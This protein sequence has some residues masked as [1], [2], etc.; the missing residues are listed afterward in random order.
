MYHYVP[1][2]LGM[3]TR[4]WI[5]ASVDIF[6][7]H[8]TGDFNH[9]S[10]F[11]LNSYQLVSGNCTEVLFL[12]IEL[13]QNWPV[14]ANVWTIAAILDYNRPHHFLW[15]VFSDVSREFYGTLRVRRSECCDIVTNDWFV[16]VMYECKRLSTATHANWNDVIAIVFQLIVMLI[17]SKIH[18]F[19]ANGFCQ[20][21]SKIFFTIT[22]SQ[23]I[24]FFYTL[25][26]WH[27]IIMNCFGECLYVF[28][29]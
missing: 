10:L 29:R 27:L 25:I 28:R 7:K 14:H 4:N 9:V 18:L 8:M 21:L 6:V 12:W 16:N 15:A 13:M 17:P 22:L 3:V 20:C 26:Y 11:I 1:L 24:V 5:G 19:E 23:W 2:V